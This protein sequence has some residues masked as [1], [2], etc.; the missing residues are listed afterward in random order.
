MIL[1][2]T[3]NTSIDKAYRI[4]STLERGTVMRVAECID[5]AGGKGLNAS[6]SV[7]TCGGRCSRPALLAATTDGSSAS[8]STATKSPTT[9]S[10]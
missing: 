5:N 4:S 8:C 3:L 6:R 7:A 9:L 1:T 2:V 10:R